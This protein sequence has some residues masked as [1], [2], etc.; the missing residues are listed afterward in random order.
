MKVLGL[1]SSLHQSG[2]SREGRGPRP[3][4]DGWRCGWAGPP[5]PACP[6]SHNNRIPAA[7]LRLRP[8][9]GLFHAANPSRVGVE[10]LPAGKLRG[11][12]SAPD[13]LSQLLSPRFFFFLFCKDETLIFFSLSLLSFFSSLKLDPISVRWAVHLSRSRVYLRCS[14]APPTV[15]HLSKTHLLSPHPRVLLAEAPR[16]LFFPAEVGMTPT[17]PLLSGRGGGANDS[18]CFVT[19]FKSVK[20]SV[21]LLISWRSSPT[22]S[23]FPALLEINALKEAIS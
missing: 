19:Y 5:P 8:S 14:V 6:V 7:F 10:L 15:T 3:G 22:L 18:I 17:S 16:S 4:S 23:R 1:I 21:V 9:R 12:R 20:Y 11:L 2:C 13:R